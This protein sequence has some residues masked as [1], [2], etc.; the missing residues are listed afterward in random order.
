M[1]RLLSLLLIISSLFAKAQTITPR[2]IDAENNKPLAYA[3]VIYDNRLRVTYTDV[4]GYFSLTT[5]SLK[6]S[7]SI[8]IQ[9][10]GYVKQ[11]LQVGSLSNGFIVKM[12]RE[13]KSLQP[14][15]VSNCPR[16]ESFT[17]NKKMGNIRQ[18]VGPG[19][20]TRLVIMA[21]YYNTTGRTVI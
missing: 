3:I 21:R 9:Y 18:Y 5:D 4:N 8:I 7:D 11:V 16:Y 10:L 17:L 1:K 12:V 14:V 2:V 13:E 15:F 19:P 6:K 20:E